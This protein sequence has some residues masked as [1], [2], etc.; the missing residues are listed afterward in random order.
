VCGTLTCSYPFAHTTSVPPLPPLDDCSTVAMAFASDHGSGKVRMS[1]S[2]TRTAAREEIGMVGEAARCSRS[3]ARKKPSLRTR[4]ERDG[5]R[6]LYAEE[7]STM[8]WGMRRRFA[9]AD[10]RD[11][12]EGLEAEAP[13]SL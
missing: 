13:W 5:R 7:L 6:A 3:Q 11:D 4:V 1:R 10:E 2:I 9:Q 8:V 12:I